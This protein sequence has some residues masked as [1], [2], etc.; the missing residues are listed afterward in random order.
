MLRLTPSAQA[1]A[2]GESTDV[3]VQLLTNESGGGDLYGFRAV[4][5]LDGPPAGLS[6]TAA[7]MPGANYV[8]Q[9]NSFDYVANPL[10]AGGDP[11]GSSPAPRVALAALPNDPFF[12]TVSANQV[13]DLG[14]LTLTTAPGTQAG[15]VGIRFATSFSELDS[16]TSNYSIDAQDGQLTVAAGPVNSTPAPSSAILFGIGSVVLVAFGAVRTGS[17]RERGAM[18]R[19]GNRRSVPFPGPDPQNSLA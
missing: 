12:V 16:A 1:L 6:F 2:A 8:F 9:G 5:Y 15:T 3:T 10:G 11:L 14:V 7:Q 13:V 18:L 19:C 17:A 4:V